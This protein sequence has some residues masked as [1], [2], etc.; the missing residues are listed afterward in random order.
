M[1]SISMNGNL[2]SVKKNDCL[3]Y[4]F[5]EDQIHGEKRAFFLFLSLSFF[6]YFIFTTRLNILVRLR[7]P[8]YWER[9]ESRKIILMKRTQTL[10]KKNDRIFHIRNKENFPIRYEWIFLKNIKNFTNL[11]TQLYT[12]KTENQMYKKNFEV[13]LT[14][15]FG[16]VRQQMISN[17][18]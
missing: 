1:I 7:H 8:G 15:A 11:D 18:I 10:F 4:Q 5:Q 14:Q 2:T 13:I 17:K 3:M 16:S 9:W 12:H 6:F